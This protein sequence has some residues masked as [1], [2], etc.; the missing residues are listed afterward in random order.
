MCISGMSPEQTDTCYTEVVFVDPVMTAKGS[1]D[2]FPF[3]FRVI[4]FVIHICNA[5][6]M[7]MHM[8]PIS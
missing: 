8:K 7:N 3:I 2:M 4:A 5:E 6:G 1:V